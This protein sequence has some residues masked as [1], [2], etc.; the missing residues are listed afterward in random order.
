VVVVVAKMATVTNIIFLL[1]FVSHIPITLFFDLQIV[2]PKWLYPTC[3]Q[4]MVVSYSQSFK[5]PYVLNPPPWY[6]SFVVCELFIQFPFFFAATYAFWKGGCQW[7]RV[8][9]MVYA[10][11]VAT[12]VLAI[13]SEI[14]FGDFSQESGPVTNTERLVL[15]AFYA[16]YLFVPLLLLYTMVTSTEYRVVHRRKLD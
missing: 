14:L 4:D 13:L 9:S 12:T 3:L 15:S 16:P 2:L 6:K 5:D 8:P 10:S 7:I 11:H 1:Y